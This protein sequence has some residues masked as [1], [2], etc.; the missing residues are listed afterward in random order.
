[1]FRNKGRKTPWKHWSSRTPLQPARH[2]SVENT[3]SGKLHL[4]MLIKDTPLYFQKKQRHHTK[5]FRNSALK[6]AWWW[7]WLIL[8]S[9]A[10][11]RAIKSR[12]W[13]RHL[14]TN[15]NLPTRD[16]RTDFVAVGLVSHCSNNC[17]ILRPFFCLKIKSSNFLVDLLSGVMRINN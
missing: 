12:L 9:R 8:P 6:L 13:R 15:T 1:M 3:S 17:S 16:F 7:L 14:E 11:I 2:A 5:S 4:T 10:R